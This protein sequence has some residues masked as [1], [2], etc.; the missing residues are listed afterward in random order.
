MTNDLIVLSQ[1]TPAAIFTSKEDADSIISKIKEEVSSIEVDVSTESGRDFIRSTAHKIARSKTAID[2]AGKALTEDWM[3]KKKA[4]DAER[5]RVWDELE[6]LQTEFRKPLTEWE[7]AKKRFVSER[8]ERIA[9]MTAIQSVIPDGS[10]VAIYEKALFDLSTLYQFDW[11]EFVGR[12]DR[13]KD[14]ADAKLRSGLAARIKA[15]EEKAELE[16]L[17][18]AEADRLQAERE[19]AIAEQAAAAA[20]AQ[21]EAAARRAADEAEAKAKAE[22]DALQRS[23]EE[24]AARE[25]ALVEAAA[26]AEADRVAAEARHAAEVEAA[27]QRERDRVAAIAKAEADAEAKRKADVAHKAAINNEVLSQIIATAA[28]THEQG[29]AIVAAIAKGE[30]AHVRIAY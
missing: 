12:A 29:K 26:K 4:V 15:D 21:A 16:R 9:A 20:K 19:K 27:A 13:A 17:R 2:A 3:L 7:D 8:E 1:I 14:D 10:D 11:Q 18:K 24:A 28:V 25:K 6:S 5:R 22:A 23:I 30:I